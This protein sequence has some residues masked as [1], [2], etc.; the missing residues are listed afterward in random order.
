MRALVTGATGVFGVHI[1]EGLLQ[2]GFEVIC[3]VRNASKADA[4][5]A[6]FSTK[7][8]VPCSYIVCDVSDKDDIHKTALK[9]EDTSIDVLINNAAITPT[10]R[11]ENR[12]GI[13][14][15]WAC[16]VLGYHWF[17]KEFT[18]N[19]MKSS[20]K[21]ACIVNVASFYA[22]GLN[23]N[24]VEFKERSYDVD[25]AYQ[26]SKQADRMLAKAWSKRFAKDQ[27]IINS[28]HPGV[29]TSG[30]S[31]GLGYDLD[32]SERA[33][34]QGAVTPLFLSLNPSV[35]QYTGEYFADSQ[36][37]QCEFCDSADDVERLFDICE[38]Y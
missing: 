5:L 21:P 25:S 33:A 19:L 13:E 10:S 8:T 15:Q 38:T 4:L 9:L 36:I 37:Q 1:V 23:L 29:A 34:R 30:V 27:I 28:C 11:S 22:G 6:K 24:D 14:E 35:S 18:P 17:I 7:Y 16:N 31:L 32:R 12:M 20:I 26:A 2:Q 3:V